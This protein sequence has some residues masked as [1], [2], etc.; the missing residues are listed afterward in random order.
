MKC[1]LSAIIVQEGKNFMM[2]NILSKNDDS[3]DCFDDIVATIAAWLNRD[4]ELMYS[5][6]WSFIYEP[7]ESDVAP[8]GN[9]INLI[10][11]DKYALLEK[12][13]GIKLVLHEK[14]SLEHTLSIICSELSESR[15]VAV[16]I[17]AFWCPSC[18]GYHLEK[19]QQNHF[20]LVVG[21]DTSNNII[22]YID[23]FYMKNNI[24][25]TMDEFANGYDGFV[26]FSVTSP[27]KSETDWLTI[28]RSII[29][30][31]KSTSFGINTFD[32]IRIFSNQLRSTLDMNREK[33]VSDMDIGDFPLIKK[34]VDISHDRKQIC[35]LLDYIAKKYIVPALAESSSR[36]RD[37]I[38]KWGMVRAL[39]CRAYLTSNLSAEL[40]NNL[41]DKIIDIAND[42]DDISS[43]L[44]LLQNSKCKSPVIDLNE[45]Y[46]SELNNTFFIDLKPYFNNKS[47]SRL[48]DYNGTADF[49]GDGRFFITDYFNDITWN[50]KLLFDVTNITENLND[51]I[52]CTTQ[53]IT[54]PK[55]KYKA[56]MIMGSAD[57]DH[58]IDKLKILYTDAYEEEIELKFSLFRTEKPIFGERIAYSGKFGK[59]I[60]NNSIKE[61]SYNG[62]L[63]FESFALKHNG[64]IN[65]ICLPYCPSMH[66]YAISL[67]HTSE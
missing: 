30:R 61:L 16:L 10:P 4:Y 21:L 58:M 17:N 65:S 36:L 43:N 59:I 24:N 49:T 45:N 19:I 47:F 28:I 67:K 22:K 8:L 6:A 38:F 48:H 55:G 63:Y 57:F 27:E 18:P 1:L 13:H 50:Y 44:M 51:N 9:S 11:Y 64:V 32:M 7:I 14:T 23:P 60:N 39:L 34:L 56:L 53:I 15:P 12:Y 62:S 40:R 25:L 66:I 2:L 37:T 54:V 26:T 33:S 35:I 3:Q 42:E 31:L 5:G 52:L 29:T 46:T 41:A 20:C